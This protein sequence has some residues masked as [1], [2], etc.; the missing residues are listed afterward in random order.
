MSTINRIAAA[1]AAALL[2]TS[3]PATAQTPAAVTAFEGARLIV[4]NGS[5]P[6]EG[7]TIIVEGAR[8]TQAGRAADVKVPANAKRVNL[9]GKTVMPMLIDTHVHL[10]PTRDALV[11]DLKRRAYFGVGA[12][13]SMGTD[14]YENLDL[15]G[16]TMP[17]AARFLSA[18]PRHHH[19]GARP[20]HRTALDQQRGGRPQGRRGLGQPQGR[21]RQDLGRQPRRQVQEADARDLRRHHRRSPQARPARHLAH[22]RPRRREGTGQGRCR[23]VRARRS[24]QG[25]RRRAGHVCSSRARLSC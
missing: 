18:G 21:H 14:K 16:H 23:R 24:R 15:R 17:D 8:I 25:H 11:R 9:A 4:G 13:L 3:L 6:I 20:H 19:A 22:L 12:V 7:A 10:S 1:T 2:A 5:A